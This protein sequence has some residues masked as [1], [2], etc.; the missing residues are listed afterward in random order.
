[1][2]ILVLNS[3]LHPL[4]SK[5]KDLTMKILAFITKKY[6]QSFVTKKD[7]TRTPVPH[8]TFDMYLDL[9]EKNP[10]LDEFLSHDVI[11]I[12][13]P[14]YNFS[15]PSTLKTWIDHVVVRNKT[16]HYTKDGVEGLTQ[17][18]K[19]IIA[20][21]RGGFYEGSAQKTF[22]DH[23]ESYLKAIFTFIGVKDLSF[24]RVEGASVQ[25][26][27]KFKDSL[28]VANTAIENIKI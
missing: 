15:I 21:S 13:A 10:F 22:W 23:Q 4:E 8:L 24:I 12:G 18:K 7:L 9:A 19:V 1:M 27:E 3:S 16:F 11:I 28:D 5:T 2:R 26:S 25:S 6:P 14:M 17:N 20:S